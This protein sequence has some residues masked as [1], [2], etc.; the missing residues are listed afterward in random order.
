MIP[1]LT[2]FCE[3]DAGSLEALL[4]PSVIN[5]L[6]ELKAGISLGILD[7]VAER[8][9]VV[10]KLNAAQIPLT[11]WILLPQ[12]QGY[13]INLENF[14]QAEQRYEQFK[15]WTAQHD[16]QWEAV[17][18]DIEPDMR[19]FKIWF[20]D[21]RRLLPKLFRRL[22]A[23]KQLKTSQAA[24]ARLVERIHEDG[25]FVESY[26]LPFILDERT[27]RSSLIRRL[28]GIVDVP[29]DREVLMLYSS[30]FRNPKDATGASA[31]S[32][33]G[34][35]ILSS[36]G[37]DAQAIAV[38]STGGGVD[39]L[40]GDFKPLEW[41]EFSRDLRL[42]WLWS[43]NIYVFSLEG[44]IERGFFSRLNTFEWDYPIL[45]PEEPARRVDAWRNTLSTI[46]WISAH[47]SYLVTAIIGLVWLSSFF[48][49]RLKKA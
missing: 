9:A 38:G 41:S 46:L 36:Y 14:S 32:M 19:D 29:T 18:F 47:F 15:S 44:C 27:A 13:W 48:R 49:N 3:L 28:F 33:A 43:E 4:T 24:Y 16:L 2:F 17:G 5:Q 45:V 23:R 21:K 7:L 26:N 31:G 42:A 1:R 8:A 37:P 25:Y 11:A 30:F 35:G 12:E 40:F 34:I 20:E 39:N 22:V 10:K 6:V